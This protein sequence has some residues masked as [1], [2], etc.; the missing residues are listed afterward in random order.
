MTK[1]SEI[2]IS[3]PSRLQELFLVIVGVGVDGNAGRKP[4]RTE[5]FGILVAI[6]SSC[7]PNG[8]AEATWPSMARVRAVIDVAPSLEP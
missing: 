8:E 6:F 5:L 3:D 4:Q 7:M 1:R 2:N